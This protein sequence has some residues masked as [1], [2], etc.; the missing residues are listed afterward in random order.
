MTYAIELDAIV[1]CIFCAPIKLYTA[2][3]FLLPFHFIF[4]KV[5][6]IVNQLLL[7]YTSELIVPVNLLHDRETCIAQSVNTVVCCSF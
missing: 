1:H 7:L 3:S 5:S 2:D 6:N 4:I